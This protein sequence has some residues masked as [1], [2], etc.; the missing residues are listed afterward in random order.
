[1]DIFSFY[2]I[3]VVQEMEYLLDFLVDNFEDI[4]IVNQIKIS[5]VDVGN[6]GFYELHVHMRENID[7]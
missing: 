4:N 2:I 1:M 3:E 7:N 5:D 6:Y